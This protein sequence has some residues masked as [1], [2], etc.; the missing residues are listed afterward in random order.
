[1]LLLSLSLL[2]S[3][4]VG[5]GG[6]DG[7]SNQGSSD[8]G[9][10]GASSNAE[11]II[12]SGE[13]LSIVS[14]GT[15]NSTALQRLADAVER[16]T[17]KRPAI[18]SADGEKTGKEIVIGNTPRPI[19]E[20]AV[21]AV[22][23]SFRH[24]VRRA[25]NYESAE[26]DLA[27]YGVYSDGSSIALAWT[28]DYF[29]ESCV[30]YF[31]EKYLISDSLTL[32]DGYIKT[33]VESKEKYLE[34]RGERIKAEAWETLKAKLPKEY[35][36]AI[37]SALQGY[38]TLCTPEMVEWLANLY[39]P[40]T[41]GFYFSNSARDNFNFYPDIESTYEA[42]MLVSS[43][44]MAEMYGG[45]W[46]AATPEWLHKQV[47]D[48]IYSL[49]N[50]DGFF[51]HPQWDKEY[52][53]ANGRQSRIT[54]DVGSAQ[55]L[56]RDLG[57]TPK[58]AI[59][60]ASYG[61]DLTSPISGSKV[62]AV[63]KVVA[64]AGMM[65]QFDS[66]SNFKNYV[67]EMESELVG[68]TDQQIAYQFY[69]WGNE[70]QTGYKYMKDPAMK[71]VLIEFFDKYQNPTT[72]LWSEQLYYD[73]TDGLHKLASVYNSLGVELKY[74]DEIIDSVLK[75]LT[76]RSMRAGAAVDIYNALSGFSY[77]YNNITK[78]GSGTAD[79]NQA[80]IDSYKNKVYESMS[81]IIYNATSQY[82]N[83]A[84]MDGSFGYNTNTKGNG[85]T[86]QGCPVAIVGT[87]EGDVNGSA[88][89]TVSVIHHI[90]KALEVDEQ[91]YVP[92]YTEAERYRF[93]SI[94]NEL[95][96]VLKNEAQVVDSFTYDFEEAENEYDI[97]LEFNL[98]QR[99]GVVM[100]E[101]DESG[102]SRLAVTS[103]PWYQLEGYN[104]NKRNSNFTIRPVS[105]SKN[106][107]VGVVE[108]DI[109]FDEVKQ[110]SNG[111]FTIHFGTN[112]AYF[113]DFPIKLVKDGRFFYAYLLDNGKN[114]LGVKLPVNDVSMKLRFEY[115]RAENVFKIY[116]NG[117][118]LAETAEMKSKGN[119][120][121]AVQFE[122]SASS[123]MKVY[124]D[125]IIVQRENVKYVESEESKTPEFE[126]PVLGRPVYDFEGAKDKKDYPRD[127]EVT[128]NS[129]S[130]DVLGS[131]GK[132]YLK[133][134]GTETAGKK[135][136]ELLVYNY[137]ET[138]EANAYVYSSYIEASYAATWAIWRN[139]ARLSF[140]D[141]DGNG[142]FTLLLRAK[143]SGSLT[144]L[145]LTDKTSLS[146]PLITFNSDGGF[147]L[148]VVYFPEASE[149][150]VYINGVFVT[151]YINSSAKNAVDSMKISVDSAVAL[152]LNIDNLSLVGRSLDYNEYK[153]SPNVADGLGKPAPEFPWIS[154]DGDAPDSG[155]PSEDMDIGGFTPTDNP[156]EKVEPVAPPDEGGDEP[157]GGDDGGGTGNEPE[158]GGEGGGD[159]GG[160]DEDYGTGESTGGGYHDGSWTNPQFSN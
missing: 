19:S 22:S 133:I 72:G 95:G 42:L 24:A 138:P 134:A 100:I 110:A 149:I 160:S 77:V 135:N 131:V 20:K 63:S 44:G 61:M 11:A 43:T 27:V 23:K 143:R 75:I 35:S 105:V 130:V 84:Y 111:S 116:V 83:F 70:F 114:D 6:G 37:I 144:Q 60:Q 126:T 139:V 15:V 153:K 156:T 155:N 107:A 92:I 127:L 86:A 65:S 18:K 124:F 112:S 103:Y 36:E 41:G 54:R 12:S 108:F 85:G 101:S 68:K 5:N 47:G 151:S 147:N 31:I 94:L 91:Y 118:F 67:A 115:Y 26:K 99:D 154:G 141:V 146:S 157:G 71:T 79:E 82:A 34:E 28:S 33:N 81:A 121:E 97:P 76:D 32:S 129:G 80:K 120:F 78:C 117:A 56:L 8:T 7:D 17:G 113:A 46:V 122:F 21:N 142:V 45:D 14:D 16:I 58:Y 73:S 150:F 90:Y 39:D 145:C 66:L 3:C 74:T 119:L 128:E 10:S 140:L 158:G 2:F 96:D 123:Q 104:T 53:E 69:S 4:K 48:W 40:G 51:Y 13:T 55:T 136:P 50:E 152:T 89:C 132:G 148:S 49:Q 25:D 159:I 30:D 125:N 1:M 52:I 57:I 64:T 102:N 87:K 98:N 106:D 88:T 137:N 38:Y 109:S 62:V 29:G 93:V 9:N 59:E